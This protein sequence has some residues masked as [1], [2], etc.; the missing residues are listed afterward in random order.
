MHKG[1]TFPADLVLLSSSEPEGMAYLET[2]NVDGE[3]NLKIRMSSPRTSHLIDLKSLT[4]FKAT[5]NCEAPSD[6]IYKFEGNLDT[7]DGCFSLDHTNVMLRGAGLRN[8]AW[9]YGVVIYTGHETKIMMNASETPQK[10]T[11]M[12][13]KTDQQYY[14]ISLGLGL[15]MVLGASGNW[16]YD[17]QIIPNHWYLNVDPKN[18]VLQEHPWTFITFIALMLRYLTVF[19]SLVPI[20]LAVTL[21]FIR[22][23]M[24]LLVSQ[25]I[26][27][28]DEDSK[29]SAVARSSSLM[30]ELGQIQC[31]LTDKTGT[32]TCNEMLLRHLIIDGQIHLDCVK[33]WP[34]GPAP[35]K[36]RLFLTILATCHTIMIDYS[37]PEK[38]CYQGSSPDE[39]TMVTTAAQLGYRLAH[40]SSGTITLDITEDDAQVAIEVF[41]VIEF[42]S[43]RKKMSIIARLPDGEYYIFCKGADSSIL[44]ILAQDEQES[45]VLEKSLKA[46]ETFACQ[47][48]R[49]LCFAYKKLPEDVATEWL[50]HWNEALNTVTDRQAKIDAVAATIEKDLSFIGATGVEDRL[51][52][53]VPETINTLMKANIKIWMLTGDRFETAISTA[54]LSN[55]LQPQTVQLHLLKKSPS[56]I[57]KSVANFL[58]LMHPDNCEPGTMFALVLNGAVIETVLSEPFISSLEAKSFLQVVRKCRTLLCCRLSPLQKSQIVRFAREHLDWVTL[59]IGDGGNDVSMIQAANV[60]VGVSGKEGLQASRSA[61]FAIAQFQFLVKLILVHG[62]W[63]FHRLS[64]VVLYSIYKNFALFFCQLWFSFYNGFSATSVYEPW[65]FINWN[66][67]FTCWPPTIIGLTDQYVLASE[68]TQNPQL[69]EFGQKNKFVRLPHLIF[70]I[71]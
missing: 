2:S 71:Y 52:T 37:D 66:L 59:A 33:S 67:V 3:S 51:Q 50:E 23:I 14:Y 44:N 53:G 11:K 31:I 46:L 17:T 65:M 8:T 63:S 34:Q 13:R 5:L 27:M 70:F 25:D 57:C 9:I 4:D 62:S 58:D 15:L 10:Q 45:P 48:L 61:D 68:L 35:E 29:T 24:A 47:G 54:F 30:E 49:T 32:L 40:R 42:T 16:Y 43:A 7:A 22:L 60:G 69:Y 64:R 21:E 6:R 20:S 1:E 56:A 19:N 39:L 28:Y 36:T 26:E 12:D 41:A 55:L 18:T 38:P